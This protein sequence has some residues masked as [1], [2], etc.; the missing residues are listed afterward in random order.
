MTEL[1][2]ESVTY[3]CN[4][5]LEIL[6]KDI[7]IEEKFAELVPFL[8]KEAGLV[9]AFCEIIVSRW[10]FIVGSK[11]FTTPSYKYLSENSDYGIMI[12]DWGRFEKENTYLIDI[13]ISN[14]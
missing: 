11:E 12:Q 5:S 2:M 7:S 8:E 14:I 10:K 6:N 13:L 4:R 9:L 3:I 1:Q